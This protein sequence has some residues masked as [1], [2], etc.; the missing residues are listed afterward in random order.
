MLVKSIKLSCIYD[1]SWR[2]LCEHWWH[3]HKLYYVSTSKWKLTDIWYKRPNETRATKCRGTLIL[4]QGKSQPTTLNYNDYPAQYLYCYT[5]SFLQPWKTALEDISR[6]LKIFIFN[7]ACAEYWF[8]F[9]WYCGAIAIYKITCWSR[10]VFQEYLH[11]LGAHK[12]FLSTPYVN[13]YTSV[14]VGM[15]IY[16][17]AYIYLHVCTSYCHYHCH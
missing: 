5:H 15:G 4:G 7:L 6:I 12:M 10:S 11:E 17:N 13:T 14:C 3:L 2:R 8:P 16:I 1:I 9:N